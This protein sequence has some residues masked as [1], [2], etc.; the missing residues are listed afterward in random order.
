MCSL[1]FAVSCT[2]FSFISTHIP[3]P[4]NWPPCFHSFFPESHSTQHVRNSF[5]IVP[6]KKKKSPL[7]TEKVQN[8][9]Y[10]IIQM[11]TCSIGL[12]TKEVRPLLSPASHYTCSW[13]W[14]SYDPNANYM[15]TLVSLL[16]LILLCLLLKQSLSDFTPVL[17]FIKF[18]LTKMSTL[19]FPPSKSN[20]LKQIWQNVNNSWIEGI[21]I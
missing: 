11:R 18:L 15:I 10:K 8:I 1:S 7:S 9:L 19:A 4:L 5:Q 16:S 17:F 20:F 3:S 6:L 12:Y 2:Q 21:G 14:C 13:A